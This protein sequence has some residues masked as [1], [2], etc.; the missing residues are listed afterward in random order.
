MTHTPAHKTYQHLNQMFTYPGTYSTLQIS[1][2]KCVIQTGLHTACS[3]CIF[4]IVQALVLPSCVQ[5]TFCVFNYHICCLVPICYM[6]VTVMSVCLKNLHCVIEIHFQ[7][8]THVTSNAH[9]LITSIGL[10]SG[11]GRMD[12]LCILLLVSVNK[13]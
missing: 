10:G 3:Q 1:G 6:F 4:H 9:Q 7:T 2:K 5:I 12:V 13:P 11:M 8:C